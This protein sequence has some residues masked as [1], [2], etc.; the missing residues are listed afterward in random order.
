MNPAG[1][2]AMLELLLGTL[3]MLVVIIAVLNSFE[4]AF[5]ETQYQ[6][7]FAELQQAG[8]RALETLVRNTGKTMD[9]ETNWETAGTIDEIQEFGL[10][11]SPLV[12]S[13]AKIL[14][15]QTFAENPDNYNKTKEKIGLGA[16]DFS[17]SLY[18]LDEQGTK[19]YIRSSSS[20]DLFFSEIGKDYLDLL[21]ERRFSAIALERAVVLNSGQVQW[22]GQYKQI[23]FEPVILELKVYGYQ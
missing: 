1:Q 21:Q 18:V 13:E 4:F 10:A 7:T 22:E 5:R 23:Y 17:I 8:E 6:G 14:K 3:L 20:S 15:F 16:F 9:G 12:L 2:T 11:S 19:N